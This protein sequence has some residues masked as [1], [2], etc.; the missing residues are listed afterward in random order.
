[1]KQKESP[2]L[3][4]YS[5]TRKTNCHYSQPRRFC[6]TEVFVIWMIVLFIV[7]V[8]LMS[9]IFFATPQAYMQT[10]PLLFEHL[11]LLKKIL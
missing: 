5:I 6:Q 4:R 7:G 2:L 10:L 11:F 9:I 8:F 1:M 3:L